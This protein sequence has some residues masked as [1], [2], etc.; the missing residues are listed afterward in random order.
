MIPLT[1]TTALLL[2][3]TLKK[4][5]IIKIRMTIMLMTRTTIEIIVMK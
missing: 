1:T 2:L 3:M 4:M 5:I